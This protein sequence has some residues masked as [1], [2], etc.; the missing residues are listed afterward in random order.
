VETNSFS[1]AGRM[2]RLSPSVVSYRIQ[3]QD[4]ALG[5]RLLTRTTRTMRLTEAGPRPVTL[6]AFYPTRR[7]SPPRAKSFVEFAVEELRRHIALELAL[8]EPV[9]AAPP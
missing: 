9:A 2:L 7:M 6:A 8:I 5:A 4:D 3:I 1:A